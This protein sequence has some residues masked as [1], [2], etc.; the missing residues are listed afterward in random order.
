[1]LWHM[2]KQEEKDNGY[3]HSY[4]GDRRDHMPY[5]VSHGCSC[6]MDGVLAMWLIIVIMLLV[7]SPETTLNPDGSITQ[8]AYQSMMEEQGITGFSSALEQ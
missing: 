1:M 8:E 2:Y 6:P 5:S 7:P 4:C 3:R